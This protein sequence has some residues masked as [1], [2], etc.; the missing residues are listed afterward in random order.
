MW[1]D[2]WNV[3]NSVVISCDFL[4]LTKG[5]LYGYEGNMALFRGS[6]SGSKKLEVRRLLLVSSSPISRFFVLH[7]L[8]H[9][10]IAKQK[11]KSCETVK[12]TNIDSAV[13]SIHSFNWHH[14]FNQRFFH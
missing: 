10:S 4:T 14:R 11:S 5:E 3:K 9:I 12:E 6:N 13:L 8:C 7:H 2:L 1:V